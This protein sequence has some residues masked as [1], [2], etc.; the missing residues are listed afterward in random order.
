MKVFLYV[1]LAFLLAVLANQIFRIVVLYRR[2]KKPREEKSESNEGNNQRTIPTRQNQY[3]QALELEL[4]LEMERKLKIQEESFTTLLSQCRQEWRDSHF[5]E[6]LWPLEPVSPDEDKWEVVEH[7]FSED[8]EIE[9]GFRRLK[10]MTFSG[11]YRLLTGSRRA[12]KWII[13]NADSLVGKGQHP[14]ILPIV[15][16]ADFNPRPVDVPPTGSNGSH[17]IFPVFFVFDMFIGPR[18]CLELYTVWDGGG[19]KKND[20]GSGCSWLILK[21]KTEQDDGLKRRM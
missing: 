18:R 20:V 4:K 8:V 11:D 6:K 16:E 3:S 2:S 10:E 5:T 7:Y 15:V 14:V 21:R 9:D 1:V 17:R 12:M 13:A 19:Q